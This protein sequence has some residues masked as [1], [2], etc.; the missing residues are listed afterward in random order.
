MSRILFQNTPV[1]CTKPT[2]TVKW[3]TGTVPAVDSEDK[4]EFSHSTQITQYSLC[5]L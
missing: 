1:D 2:Y 4:G 5:G 3:L